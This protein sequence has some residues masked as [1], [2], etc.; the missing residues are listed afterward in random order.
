MATAQDLVDLGNSLLTFAGEID[1][2]IDG[3][4]N[5]YDQAFRTLRTVEGQIASAANQVASLA[6]AMLAPDVASA[7]QDLTSKVK[8]AQVVLKTITNVQ[9]AAQIVAA[10]LAV[11]VAAA[12][13]NPF[14]AASSVD[15][16]ASQLQS[17]LA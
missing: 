7:T 2:Y 8:A 14:S 3:Q 4:S 16:L 12:T 10:V 1:D 13:G 5:P 11:A 15:Q 17:V 6:I 9:K